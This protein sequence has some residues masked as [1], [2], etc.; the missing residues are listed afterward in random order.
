MFVYTCKEQ[1][2]YSQTRE[3]DSKKNND[4]CKEGLEEDINQPNKTNSNY[5][6][7]FNKSLIKMK[8]TDSD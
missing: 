8:M 7:A 5:K 6:F 1:K 4:D 3:K 2:I